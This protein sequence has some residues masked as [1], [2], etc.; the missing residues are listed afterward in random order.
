MIGGLVSGSPSVPDWTNISLGDSA[1]KST[2]ANLANLPQLENLAGQTNLFNAQQIQQMLGNIPGFTGLSNQITDVLG[3]ELRGEIPPDVAAAI[4]NNAA[5]QALTGGFG[6]SGLAG[7]LTARDL[8][9][10]SL[11]IMQSGLSS[12]ESWLG[13]LDKMYQPG[14]F[15]LSSMFITPQQEFTAEMQNQ[16]AAWNRDWLKSQIDY[17]S[18]F[19]ALA[20]NAISDWFGGMDSSFS[21]LGG[22]AMGT[23]LGGMMA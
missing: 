19:G 17:G 22:R 2:S 14:L 1:S 21:A 4:Q 16:E 13:M 11:N 15:N 5:A 9:L 7:N 12:A 18:S 8:G 6:G 3:S 23:G 10:T 20:G